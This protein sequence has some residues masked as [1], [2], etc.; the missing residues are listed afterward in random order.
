MIGLVQRGVL[1]A[2]LVKQPNVQFEVG[3]FNWIGS[4]SPDLSLVVAWYT[5]R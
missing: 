4:V 2:Q 1:L 3:K 5:R